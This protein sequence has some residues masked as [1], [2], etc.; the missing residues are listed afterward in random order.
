MSMLSIVQGFCGRT[1]L[2]VPNFVAGAPDSQIVQ[3]QS[4]LNEVLEDLCD[5]WTWEALT[6]E[7]VFTTSLGEDQGAITTIAPNGYLRIL[8]E[9]IFNRTLRLPL[10]GPMLPSQWQQ[11]KALPNTGPFYK[12]RI[13]GGRLLFN[14]AGVSGHTCSF[15]YASSYCV[16]AADGTTYKPSFTADT[17]TSVFDEKLLIAGLRWKWKSE[18]GLDYAEE[19]RRY[20]ELANN[21]AGR[22]ATKPRLSMNAGD[23]G[24]DFRP[25]IWVPSGNWSV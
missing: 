6:R 15:E 12:Y 4:L 1:G 16:L 24:G 13:R 3:V 2:P 7:A 5:R 18:K 21:A 23:E 8:Q 11:L 25:G 17:D 22:D 10:F 9:T 20:E 19:L 14:P